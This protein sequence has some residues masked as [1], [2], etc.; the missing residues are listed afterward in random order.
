MNY[1]LFHFGFK[2]Q[3]KTKSGRLFDVSAGLAK[4]VQLPEK[5]VICEYCKTS[6]AG[7]KYLDT[8]VRFKHPSEYSKFS[9]GSNGAKVLPNDLVE[10]SNNCQSDQQFTK[11]RKKRA[12]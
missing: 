9:Q 8:H 10:E 7:K 4:T 5:S 11:R 2:K 6:Y 12:I 1:T 3:V